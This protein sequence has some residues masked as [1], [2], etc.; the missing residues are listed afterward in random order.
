MVSADLC[1]HL[2]TIMKSRICTIV[3]L[4]IC[5][6]IAFD[7]FARAQTPVDTRSSIRTS[8]APKTPCINDPDLSFP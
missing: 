5:V 2:F 4:F 8:A 3:A 7:G 1:G 6:Q